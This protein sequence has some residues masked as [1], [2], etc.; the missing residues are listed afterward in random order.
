[1]TAFQQL[2]FVKHYILAL[3]GWTDFSAHLENL[4]CAVASLKTIVYFLLFV[5]LV[6]KDILIIFIKVSSLLRCSNSAHWLPDLLAQKG[7]AYIAR[8][9]P[10]SWSEVKVMV[11]SSG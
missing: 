7:S 2:V 9:C 5:C 4:L 11:G 1:M 6:C 8:D 3:W 10:V